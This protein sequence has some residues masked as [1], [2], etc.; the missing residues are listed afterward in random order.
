M[1]LFYVILGVFK[2]EFEGVEKKND[3]CF[4]FKV[5]IK[6]IFVFCDV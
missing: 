2:I 4:C 6:L 1:N 3:S 5:I